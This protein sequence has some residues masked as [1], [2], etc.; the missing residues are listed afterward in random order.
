MLQEHIRTI[1]AVVNRLNSDI[2]QLEESIRTRDNVSMGTNNA[3]KNLEVHHVASLTDLRGRIVRCD[4]SIARLS[5]ELNNA[6]AA[7]KQLSQQQSDMQGK[8]IERIHDVEARLVTVQ[9]N[10]DRMASEN[11]MK[12]QHLEGDTGQQMATL[13]S[14]TKSIIDDLKNTL[15]MYQANSDAEREKLEARLLSK[16]Y[17]FPLLII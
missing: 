16:N 4:T 9:N 17:Y 1:T 6:T 12:L 14:R 8:I 10:Q 11:K 5:T 2:S 3:V 15:N 13:D 7:I